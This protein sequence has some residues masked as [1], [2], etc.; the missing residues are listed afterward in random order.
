VMY[1]G[2]IVEHGKVSEVFASPQHPYTQG[3][4]ACLPGR[5]RQLSKHTGQTV[6]LQD[7]PG[8]APSLAELPLGC[9]FAPRCGACQSTCNQTPPAWRGSP[10]HTALCH[11]DFSA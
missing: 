3:L 6:A 2:Q 7:I 1:A 11:F 9:S 8:Q 10:T 4:L 5:A